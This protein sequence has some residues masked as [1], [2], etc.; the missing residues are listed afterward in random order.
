VWKAK[1]SNII[2]KEKIKNFEKMIVQCFWQNSIA[3]GG[4]S[5]KGP[6]LILETLEL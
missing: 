1:L 6:N 5:K 3:L 2:R 4:Y